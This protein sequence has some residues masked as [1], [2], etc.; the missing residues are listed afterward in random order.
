MKNMALKAELELE[1]R[2]LTNHSV[3]KTLVMNLKA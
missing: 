1:E 2:M 3:R